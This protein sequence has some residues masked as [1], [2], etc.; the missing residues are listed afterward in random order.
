MYHHK[1]WGGDFDKYWRGT[2]CNR[3]DVSIPYTGHWEDNRAIQLAAW[4]AESR[5]NGVGK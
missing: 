4:Q 3:M 5:A 1:D 2:I